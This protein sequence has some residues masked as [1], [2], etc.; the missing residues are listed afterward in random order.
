[1]DGN[2]QVDKLAVMRRAG[3]QADDKLQS[4]APPLSTDSTAAQEREHALAPRRSAQMIDSAPS[5]D[6]RP[7]PS[8]VAE[9]DARQEELKEE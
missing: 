5:P 7:T 8:R 1:M 3:R 9:N 2:L 4:I 6:T